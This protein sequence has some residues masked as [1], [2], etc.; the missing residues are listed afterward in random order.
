MVSGRTGVLQTFSPDSAALGTLL[1]LGTFLFLG[2]LLIWEDKQGVL[3][4]D[5]AGPTLFLSTRRNEK[6][7]LKQSFHQLL[8]EHCTVRNTGWCFWLT[9]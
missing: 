3:L 6:C 8:P 7:F 9:D 4:T 1:C 5:L 2:T